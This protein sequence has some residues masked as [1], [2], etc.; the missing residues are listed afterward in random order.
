M[1]ENLDC[2][3]RD[4]SK[5]DTMETEELEEILRSDSEAP[6]GQEPDTEEL[7]YVMEV[8]ANRKQLNS[9]GKT[10]QEAWESFQRNYLPE[11]EAESSSELGKPVKAARYWLRR[12]VAAAAVLVLLICAVPVVGAFQWADLWK[13][14]ATWAK[15]TFSFISPGQTQPTEPRPDNFDTYTSLQEALKET[16]NTTNLVPTWIPE[17]YILE[18]IVLDESPMQ[19]T[20]IALYING[21]AALKITVQAYLDSDPEKVEVNDKLLE[22][23]KASGVEYYIFSNHEQ[24]RAAWTV[25][26]YECYI[27]GELTL[28]EM[29]Q[30]IDSIWKG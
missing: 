18:K 3:I 2:G 16:N 6:Q 29:K 19:R 1:S 15:E 11:Q 27:S 12:S 26:S 4:F 25:D 28:E 13:A 9:T 20:Y 8:L 17:R 30:M 14:V 23:Y 7:L 21:D 10:A 5:Y 22:V 24:L